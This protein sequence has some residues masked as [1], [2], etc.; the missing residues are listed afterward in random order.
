MPKPGGDDS[1]PGYP[2]YAAIAATAVAVHVATALISAREAGVG[3][4]ALGAYFDGHVYLEIA[5]SF[6]LPFAPGALDYTGHPP[7]YPFLAWLLR[8]LLPN[9][10]VDW[11]GLL[12]LAAWLPAGAAAAAFYAVCRELGAPALWPTALFA[13]GNPRLFTTAASAHSEPL[14]LA[15]ALL[16]LLAFL[17]GR[18]G[19]CLAWITLAGFARFAAFLLLAPLLAGV[20]LRE[21]RVDL[22]TLALFAIPP[23]LFGLYVA[24]LHARVPAF[25]SLAESHR[26]FWETHFTWPFRALI[27]SF[28]ATLW[29][30]THPSFELTYA[31]VGF[32][33]AAFAAGT[34]LALRSQRPETWVLTLWIGIM[35]GVHVSLS[36]VLGAWDFMRLSA[37]A[38]PAALAILAIAVGREAPRSAVAALA[39]VLATG[40]LLYARAQMSEAVAWQRDS[41]AWFLPETLSRLDSDEP[42]WRDFR[43]RGAEQALDRQRR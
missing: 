19:W 43:A 20:L 15:L 24:Y 33:L 18:L 3:L 40:S 29:S 6:P 27:R 31:S 38:W 14:V 4:S 10:W 35:V 26:V 39:I 7:G 12:L 9:A 28:D 37:L 21:R 25:V 42:R 22:R 1:R 32:Y 11:G 17:R 13:F 36:G 5:R 16:A 8:A 2:V 23:A 41:Q 30:R 34:A